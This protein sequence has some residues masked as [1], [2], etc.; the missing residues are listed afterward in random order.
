MARRPGQPSHL[1]RWWA[2]LMRHFKEM[3]IYL[4]LHCH[5]RQCYICIF[6]NSLGCNPGWVAGAENPGQPQFQGQVVVACGRP[7]WQRTPT[8]TI[9]R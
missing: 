1:W 3:R 2:D 8:G 7:C 5:M 9:T 6:V 4:T